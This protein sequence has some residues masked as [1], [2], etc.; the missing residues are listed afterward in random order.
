MN[1]H[2]QLLQQTEADRAG[3]LDVPIIQGALQGQVS[4]PSYI[5]FLTEAYHHVKHTVPLLQA[6]KAALPA[7]HVW[8]YGAMDEYV[9]E[10]QGHDEW[11]LD[12]IRACGADAESVRHGRPGHATEMMVAYAYDT[13]ARGN[14]LGF[15]GM[16]HVLEGT[17]V[18]LALMAADHIQSGL[19]LPDSAFSYL[20]SHGTLDLEHTAH[21]ALLMERIEDPQDQAAIVHAARAFFRLYADVFRGLP[22]PQVA[23]ATAQGV[24]A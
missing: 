19:G 12:D 24:P 15:F 3:L 9:E 10:E 20:R 6:C 23:S 5:A 8:L 18:A 7:H 14:P 17:S 11:I 21:F 2:T 16:V 4:L 22:L 13:I 1:F